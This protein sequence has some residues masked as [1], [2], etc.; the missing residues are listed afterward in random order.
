[1]EQPLKLKHSLN[2]R[3]IQDGISLINTDTEKIFKSVRLVKQVQR[4][5]DLH[6]PVYPDDHYNMV[7]WTLTE[8]VKCQKYLL[9]CSMWDATKKTWTLE[10]G[11]VGSD[12]I[13]DMIW[14]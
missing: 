1:M 9:V 7:I 8:V 12:G 3:I 14:Q 2:I 6:Q 11:Y 4:P 5:L 13:T 10:S